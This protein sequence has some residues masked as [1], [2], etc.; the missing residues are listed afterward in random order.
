MIVTDGV[1]TSPVESAAKRAAR[2]GIII[3]VVTIGNFYV[4]QQL[5]TIANNREEHIL[6]VETFDELTSA[7]LALTSEKICKCKY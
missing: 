6:T 7:T 3:I 4:R 1:A 5:M 2:E